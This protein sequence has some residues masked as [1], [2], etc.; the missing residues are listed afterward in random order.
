MQR[1]NH[2]TKIVNLAFTQGFTTMGARILHSKECI[3]MMNE[4]DAFAIDDH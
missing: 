2:L 3:G 1:T 4:T